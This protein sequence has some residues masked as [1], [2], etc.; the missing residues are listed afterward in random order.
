VIAVDDRS[1]D[2][3]PALLTSAARKNSRLRPLR[4]DTLP[5]GWLGKPHALKQAYEQS[6]GEWIVFTDADV[7]FAPDVLRR[8]ITL[9][10]KNNWAHL[11]LLSTV[12]MFT[13]GEKTALTFFAVAFLI[14]TRPWKARNRQSPAY[15][16]VGAFQMMRRSAYQKVGTHQRLAMEVVDDM[17][18]G[19]LAKQA[20]VCSGVARAED[21]VSVHW[22]AGLGNI[23]R[24]T[25]KN[26]FAA[27]GYRLSVAIVQI[28][29]VLWLCVFPALALPFVQGWARVFAGIAA[30]L[31]VV[32]T[33]AI[34]RKLNA[35]AL[36][37]LTF[38]VGALLFAWM[39]T[40][41][42]ILTLWRR[43]IVWRGTFYP[44]EELR[45]GVV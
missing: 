24:G 6:S 36:Y 26:F 1:E 37:A 3:T 41:S 12:R 9:A 31:P 28:L 11:T 44:L 43:G 27:T 13:F 15:S 21:L 14:G 22:Q 29:G 19:K 8:A 30:G 40:R 16:G 45:R 4:V 2:S 18:L 20:G 35:P 42:T 34:A 5:P 25:T 32:V 23:I 38:P 39:L 17:K 7:H 10:N 33:A